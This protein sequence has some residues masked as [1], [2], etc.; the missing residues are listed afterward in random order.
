MAQC[1][2]SGGNGD[3][4]RQPD[5]H[6]R[7]ENNGVGDHILAVKALFQAVV[8]VVYDADLAGLRAGA[9]GCGNGEER[10]GAV[11]DRLSVHLIVYHGAAVGGEHGHGLRAVQHAAAAD[12]Q[13]R[14]AAVRLGGDAVDIE[15]RGLGMEGCIENIFNTGI[16]NEGKNIRYTFRG[17]GERQ[18][19]DFFI[20]NLPKQL[21]NQSCFSIS[22]ENA[23]VLNH[24]K[25]EFHRLS[26][27]MTSAYV[28]I[29]PGKP[30]RRRKRKGMRLRFG[31]GRR[32]SA[33]PAVAL[34]GFVK[35]DYFR[36][37]YASFLASRTS[38]RPMV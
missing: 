14:A 18:N 25:H 15:G 31:G 1:V 28:S 33:F 5:G 19:Q 9:R 4:F 27:E 30:D 12:G 13:N 6:K 34:R 36:T 35:L 38:C 3:A 10:Q 26:N 2:D 21:G 22:K 11:D 29:L 16:A 17:F 23:S 20:G 24:I 8:R 32:G 7:V 37:L